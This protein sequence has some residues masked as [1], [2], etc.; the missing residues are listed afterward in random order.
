MASGWQ[1][2]V[3]AR[4]LEGLTTE[5]EASAATENALKKEVEEL[6]AAE[7]LGRTSGHAMGVEAHMCRDEFE[8]FSWRMFGQSIG[9]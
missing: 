7:V 8:G 1:Q 5:T 2:A 4:R 9:W 3:L 6:T